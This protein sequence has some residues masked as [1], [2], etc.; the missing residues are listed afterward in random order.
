M[1]KNEK[2]TE[3]NEENCEKIKKGRKR[4][5]EVLTLHIVVSTISHSPGVHIPESYWKLCVDIDIIPPDVHN[6][7]VQW[8]ELLAQPLRPVIG[9]ECPVIKA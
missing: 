1:R 7:S 5:I 9:S 3:E 4:Q 6:K 8:W 2:R